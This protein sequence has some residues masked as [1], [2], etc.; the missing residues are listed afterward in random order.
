MTGLLLQVVSLPKENRR[1]RLVDRS[2]DHHVKATG[3]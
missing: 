3:R 1:H 2:A